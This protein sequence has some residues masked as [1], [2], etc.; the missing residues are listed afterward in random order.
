MM[1]EPMEEVL[2]TREKAQV[3]PRTWYQFSLPGRTSVSRA[4]IIPFSSC[5]LPWYT[6][7]YITWQ[8][9]WCRFWNNLGISYTAGDLFWLWL[10]H[11]FNV[12]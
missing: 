7:T 6:S 8:I 4:Q 2:Y 12:F 9:L 5:Q 3:L 1:L 10:Y 11:G